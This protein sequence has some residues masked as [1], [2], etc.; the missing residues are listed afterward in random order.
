M[1]DQERLDL[2]SE[3]S[4][5]HLTPNIGPGC[6]IRHDGRLVWQTGKLLRQIESHQV[7]SQLRPD[8]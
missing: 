8:P 6:V 2:W 1:V 5:K 7:I 4:R 3:N